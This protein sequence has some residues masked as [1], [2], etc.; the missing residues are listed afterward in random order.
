MDMARR[1]TGEVVSAGIGF[2]T[3]D[4]ARRIGNDDLFTES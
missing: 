2:L 4:Q 1:E 3:L